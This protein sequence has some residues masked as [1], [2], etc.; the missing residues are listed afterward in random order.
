[1]PDNAVNFFGQ[2]RQQAQ[3][4]PQRP[5]Q[6]Q[7]PQPQHA[8]DYQSA[9]AAQQTSNRR[10]LRVCRTA[11]PDGM[12][13][14]AVLVPSTGTVVSYYRLP[15]QRLMKLIEHSAARGVQHELVDTEA[16]MPTTAEPAAGEPSNGGAASAYTNYD[17][18]SGMW[19][20]N[21]P[22]DQLGGAPVND[23][24]VVPLPAMGD[25]KMS[26]QTAFG[27]QQPTFETLEQPAF[28]C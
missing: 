12:H 14:V 8:R 4:R 2:P 25:L 5:P 10:M 15:P 18:G 26:T 11:G 6:Q 3:L 20:S 23:P 16:Q 21:V 19:N 17:A 9:V 27:A 1:M 13:A 22:P 7:Q 28:D 24:P